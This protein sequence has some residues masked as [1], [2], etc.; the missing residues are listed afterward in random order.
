MRDPDV[1]GAESA[2]PSTPG[3]PGSARL[4]PHLY[5]PIAPPGR[6]RQCRARLRRDERCTMKRLIALVTGA[7][8]A[9]RRRGACA[10]AAADVGIGDDWTVSVQFPTR[11][12]DDQFLPGFEPC[13]D[14]NDPRQRRWNRY[15]TED[16]SGP[17]TGEIRALRVAPA[18]H[19]DIHDEPNGSG[20]DSPSPACRSASTSTRPLPGPGASTWLTGTAS[21]PTSSTPSKPVP[22]AAFTR[23][24]PAQRY[25]RHVVPESSPA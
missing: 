24:P 12:W 21:V 18:V 7:L 25:R 14:L 13:S 8:I 9:V 22:T 17:S 5:R 20:A 6:H 1:E 10:A 23:R 19:G 2:P 11:V 4:R 16:A 15:R 3:W